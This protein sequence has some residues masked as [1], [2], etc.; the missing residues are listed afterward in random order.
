MYSSLYN[1][2]NHIIDEFVKNA[3]SM[4]WCDF[5]PLLILFGDKSEFAF[6]VRQLRLVALFYF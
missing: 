1:G 2:E 4:R 3:N 5:N 6:F